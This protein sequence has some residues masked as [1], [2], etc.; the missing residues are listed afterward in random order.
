MFKHF[1]E[2]LYLKALVNIVV[3]D[4]KTTVYIEMLNKKGLV[5]SYEEEFE[6]KYLSAPMYEYIQSN[7]KETPYYYI[8]ILDNSRSQGA[9]PT[10]ARN[11]RAYYHD[12]SESEY[13]CYNDKWTYYTSKT[14]VYAM[15][16]VYKKIGIDFIFSPFLILTNFFK[17][18][19]DTPLAMFILIEEGS[20][21][22]SIFKN[23]ELLFAEYLD[24]K[25]EVTND[26]LLIEEEDIEDVLLEEDSIDLDDIDSIDELDE[27][28]TFGDIAD[29]DSIDELDEFGDTRDIEEA[30]A[31]NEEIEEFP[32]EESDGFN[33]DY[34]RFLLIQG[35]VNSYYQSDKFESEFIENTY[36]GDGIGVS[37]DFKKYLEEDMFLNVYVRHVS[38]SAEL[39]EIAKMELS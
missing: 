39:C 15:E 1:Y 32:V 4:S 21:C 10:C 7:I 20:L 38:L 12:L 14:D 35:A 36:V 17:D 24:M 5:H 31:E 26:S 27:L 28:D 2:N 9:L 34:Q 22:L 13:K 23:S 8:S 25:A 29:L 18:K 37:A 3:A 6:E 16:K 30:L 19:I 11:K 33:R